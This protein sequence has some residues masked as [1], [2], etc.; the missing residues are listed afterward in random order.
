MQIDCISSEKKNPAKFKNKGKHC[1]RKG[2]LISTFLGH[3]AFFTHK[4][5]LDIVYPVYP[6]ATEYPRITLAACH[7]I[8]CL[9]FQFWAVRN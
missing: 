7:P 2:D 3:Q 4:A 1:T 6:L 8:S 5:F 9:E